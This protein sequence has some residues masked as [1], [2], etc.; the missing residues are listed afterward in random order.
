[1]GDEKRPAR[2][3]GLGSG[4]GSADFKFEPVCGLEIALQIDENGDRKGVRVVVEKRPAR[5][6]GLGSGRGPADSRFGPFR[7]RKSTKIV[8]Q[9]GSAW[10]CGLCLY[11]IRNRRKWGPKRDLRGRVGSDREGGRQTLDSDQPAG[12]KLRSRRGSCGP[13]G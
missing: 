5:Q 12:F 10:S 1:M 4:R 3:C 6:C 8:F 2:P 9:K 11:C 13:S 7:G